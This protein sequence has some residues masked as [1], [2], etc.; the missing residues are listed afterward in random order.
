LHRA[1]GANSIAKTDGLPEKGTVQ[2]PTLDKELTRY[3]L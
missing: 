3:G 1:G 2:L